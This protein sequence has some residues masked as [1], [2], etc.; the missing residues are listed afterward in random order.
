MWY[1]LKA[2]D[3]PS[4]VS[5][6]SKAGCCYEELSEN[7]SLGAGGIARVYKVERANWN[8]ADET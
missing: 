7:E 8:G 3:R 1:V 2:K 4:D 5:L 6:T